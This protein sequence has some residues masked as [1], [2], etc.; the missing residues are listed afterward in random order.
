[1]TFIRKF[2]CLV[3]AAL[4]GFITYKILYRP[5]VLDSMFFAKASY[6]YCYHVVV[7]I[8]EVPAMI[9]LTLCAG[10]ML[11]F[12]ISM[13]TGGIIQP[14]IPIEIGG[15]IAGVIGVGLTIYDLFVPTW[16]KINQAT[17]AEIIGASDL[18]ID[19]LALIISV[20]V[21]VSVI[22]WFVSHLTI[23]RD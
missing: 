1:M 22:S 23:G 4:C 7:R 9:I 3:I 18:I 13:I 2:L 8:F 19:E 11:S 20:V 17:E 14:V 16:V 15:P 21:L 5:A 10:Y 12:A 6:Y